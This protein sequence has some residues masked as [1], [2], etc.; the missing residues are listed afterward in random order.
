MILSPTKMSSG[1]SK[2]HGANTQR[3]KWRRAPEAPITC[4]IHDGRCTCTT[5]CLQLFFVHPAVVIRLDAHAWV[6][7]INKRRQKYFPAPAA[8]HRDYLSGGFV[9][10][11]DTVHQSPARR[12]L[13]DQY[14]TARMQVKI[15][16]NRQTP[17]SPRVLEC[18]ADRDGE[19]SDR[20][21]TPAR[22]VIYG[23]SWGAEHY[24]GS[25][26]RPGWNSGVAHDSGRQRFE[27]RRR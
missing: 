15:F 14:H 2:L 10:R 4:S 13:R 20:E 5:R 26:T 9:R 25:K 17:G 1:G 8:R 22:I 24:T 21:K 16:E 19:L 3:R 27:A 23:H 12:H 11:N 6:P 7:G 18:D